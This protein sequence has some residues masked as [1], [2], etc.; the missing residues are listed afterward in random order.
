M[1]RQHQQEYPVW[2]AVRKEDLHSTDGS[3]V[4][5]AGLWNNS[6][7]LQLN[8][9]GAWLRNSMTVRLP[10][11]QAPLQLDYSARLCTALA[12][13]CAAL[14]CSALPALLRSAVLEGLGKMA[15]F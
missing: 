15:Y 4:R 5:T 6:V 1:S 3:V 9:A 11:G 7:L 13:L 8:H 2:G 14:L 12:P 10:W